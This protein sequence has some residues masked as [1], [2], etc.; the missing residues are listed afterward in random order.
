[1]GCADEFGGIKLPDLLVRNGDNEQVTLSLTAY[2][3]AL[4]AT[5]EGCCLCTVLE[6]FRQHICMAG[7]PLDILG[8]PYSTYLGEVMIIIT[9]YK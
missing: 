7:S 1:M 8:R 3:L 5:R 9:I 2:L 4:G 6:Q